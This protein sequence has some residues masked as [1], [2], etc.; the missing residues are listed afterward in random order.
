MKIN[1]ELLVFAAGVGPTALVYVA[2]LWEN[3]R[4]AAHIFLIPRVAQQSTRFLHTY[5]PDFHH[6]IVVSL[7]EPAIVAILQ[8]FPH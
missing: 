8:M 2:V 7:V 4:A 5:T 1:S 3:E 6:C